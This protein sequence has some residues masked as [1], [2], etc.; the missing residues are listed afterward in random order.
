MYL[1]F[2]DEGDAKQGQHGCVDGKG[3]EG[4][5]GPVGLCGFR[6]SYGRHCRALMKGRTETQ[7]IR[8]GFMEALRGNECVKPSRVQESSRGEKERESVCACVKHSGRSS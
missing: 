6:G 5:K 7:G 8:F 4:S 2:L 3:A 1:L